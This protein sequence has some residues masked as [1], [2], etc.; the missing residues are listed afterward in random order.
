MKHEAVRA[1][2]THAHS[3]LP[4]RAVA[5]SLSE[6]LLSWLIEKEVELDRAGLDDWLVKEGGAWDIEEA[7]AATTLLEEDAFHTEP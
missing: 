1:L 6:V 2:W 7:N 3:V 5:G 4:M